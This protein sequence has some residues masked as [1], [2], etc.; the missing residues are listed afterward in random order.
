MKKIN[1]FTIN[2]I[3]VL[4][5]DKLFS[6]YHKKQLMDLGFR[7]SEA[8]CLL[9]CIK[10]EFKEYLSYKIDD[11][12]IFYMI[13]SIYATR[14]YINRPKKY[15]YTFDY[16]PI[17]HRVSH[18]T[19]KIL[20]SWVK[21]NHPHNNNHINNCSLCNMFKTFKKLSEYTHNYYGRDKILKLPDSYIARILYLYFRYRKYNNI[22]DECIIYLI[23]F[24]IELF[25]KDFTNPFIDEHK[26][27]F[28]NNIEEYFMNK[29]KINIFNSL[30]I[31]NY[32]LPS[33]LLTHIYNFI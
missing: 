10:K 5:E 3:I 20:I 22:D 33:E 11:I 13:S 8:K 30:I 29:K 12:F 26:N 32:H 31:N 14:Y 27:H 6:D 24:K 2:I 21:R 7:H 28:Y 1:S 17:F 16:L 9:N 25:N 15:R 4:M 23:I 18:K 19:K